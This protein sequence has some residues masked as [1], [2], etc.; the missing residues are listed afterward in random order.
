[1]KKTTFNFLL[2]TLLFASIGT[3]AQNKSSEAKVSIQDEKWQ[4]GGLYEGFVP[5]QEILEKRTSISKHFKNANGTHTAQVGNLVH[6][7]DDSGV[8]QDIDYAITSNPRAVKNG[9]KYSNETNE[10][11]SYFPE[12]AGKKAVQM[13][14]NENLNFNWWK[15]P[16]LEF[17]KNGNIIGQSSLKEQEGL[18]KKNS[19]IYNNVYPGISEEFEVLPRG[20]E[21][22]TIIHS[23]ND[24]IKNL[25]SGTIL[26]FSQIIELK[27]GWSIIS[28][29][30]VVTKNFE[31]ANFSISI[32]GFDEGLSFSPI[33]VFDNKISKD[34][35]L[36]LI[37]AP[38]EKLTAADFKKLES[39]VFQSNYTAEFTD[40]GLKITTKLPLEWLK[41]TERSFPV[42]IDPTVTIGAINQGNFY[43]PLTHWY[44]FQRHAN[45]YLQS[46]VGAYGTITAIEYYKT[47]T[48]ATRN[49]PTKVYM[50]TTENAT[51]TTSAWNSA[52]YTG[53][54]T[55][56]FDGNT[57]QDN[58]AGWKMVTLTD[59]FNYD[60]GNLVVMVYDEYGGSGATQYFS[61]TAATAP[62]GR[63]AHRRADSTN[64]GDGAMTLE[65]RLQSIRI[66]YFSDPPAI[67]SFSPTTVCS[68]SGTVIITGTGLS[69]TSAV[70]VGGT[71]VTS[72][73][74]NSDTQITAVVGAGT[75]GVINVTNISGAANSATNLTVNTSPTVA[76]IAGGAT[77]VCANAVSPAFTNATTGG[78]W[79]VVN[80]TGSATISTTGI[81]S[82]VSVGT[83]TVTYTFSDGTCSTT[84]ST[85]VTV[86]PIPSAVTINGVVSPACV[87][88][89]QT[90]TTSGGAVDSTFI[91][92]AFSASTMPS[93]WT[94]VPGAGDF[95]TVSATANAGGT[96]NE[97]RMAC[98]SFSNITDRIYYGPINTSGLT[99]LSLQWRSYVDHW[100]SSYNY[101]VSVQTSTDAITWNNTGWGTSPVTGNIGPELAS[102]TISTSDVGSPTL[103]IA[104]TM[105]GVTFG[106]DAWSIDDVNLSGFA[107]AT[108]VWSPITGLYTNAAATIPYTGTS[109]TTIYAN[110]AATTAYTVTATNPGGC[111]STGAA[112]IVVTT[113]IPTQPTGD[114]AQNFEAGQ[115]LANLVV[116]GTGL[117]WHSDAA[118]TIVLPNSTPLV[119]GATYYVS[120]TVAGCQ[121]PT[122]GV[123]V[124][125]TLSTDDFETSRFKYYPNPVKNSLTLSHDKNISTVSVYN[126]LGQQVLNKSINTNQTALDMSGLP[127]G[128][129]LVK[130]N[131]ENA[132]K[133]IK[134][135]KQ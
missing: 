69:G 122:L 41:K 5:S 106:A 56:L 51:L 49:K 82:G 22:N 35:A 55:P 65:N 39:Y 134:V 4:K 83:V 46:E 9:Y 60:S 90:L 68:N 86:S 111:T 131:I 50:R 74:V 10:I 105:T 6:Y 2:S 78:T 8:W 97:I 95:I 132:T 44:G 79:G 30:K 73:I 75:T 28:N 108:M 43:G 85:P 116:S 16:K 17:R 100:S 23:L 36:Y 57:T 94:A 114:I 72:F 115:T 11:K 127:L 52:T 107:P 88:K 118:G 112:N 67:T 130:V 96:A 64:P 58:T 13:K 124:T 34:E 38:K 133:T 24:Q 98:N 63:Q 26:E 12:L 77:S 18:S 103:Y 45:L 71:A 121:S 3:F 15:N 117:V 87:G 80:G 32:P 14:I 20:L 110:P 126:L 37:N 7:K 123:T 53:S 19:I 104:F 113:A 42:T 93:S 54:L 125:L 129:Y 84:V 62:A 66:T 99:E 101:S 21:N 89:I 27:K 81:L 102:T 25:P 47:N 109:T 70:T 120:Q 91:D 61:Q 92:E 40:N 59:A 135:V 29:G 31:A 33:V 119:N 128:T 1:M 76:P 48:A